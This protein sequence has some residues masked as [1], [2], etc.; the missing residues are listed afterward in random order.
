[1]R[2]G[3]LR[4]PLQLQQ[5]VMGVDDA[6]GPTWIWPSKPHPGIWDVFAKVEPLT[7]REWAQQEVKDSADYRITIRRIPSF[8]VVMPTA[9]WRFVDPYLGMIYNIQTVLP[10]QTMTTISFLVRTPTGG[11]DGR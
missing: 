6:G 1:M 9:R 10:E 7:G 8:A 11:N 2:A 5:P 3:E 4:T